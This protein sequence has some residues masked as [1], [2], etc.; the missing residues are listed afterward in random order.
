V[1]YYTVNDEKPWHFSADFPLDS[2][3]NPQL[4]LGAQGEI[5]DGIASAGTISYK[6]RNDIQIFTSM[7]RLDRR[8]VKD[9]S[10]ENGKCVLFTSEPLEKDLELTGF[11]VVELYVTST[12]K[13]GIFLAE[14]E[15]VMPD[16]FCQGI[17]EGM[18]RGRSAALGRNQITNSLGLPFHSSLKK[19]DIEL[20]ATVPTQLA[21][22]MEPTSRILKAGSRIRL[23]VYCGGNGFNQPEGMPDDVTVTFHFGGDN[24]ALLRLPVIAPNVTCFEGKD[25]TMY[26]FKRAVYRKTESGWK[27]Y[28]C[29]QVYP[30]ADGTRFVTDQ[31]TA[32]R[33]QDGDTVTL[34]VTDGP[35]TFTGTGKLSDRLTFSEQSTEIISTVDARIRRF[36]R[37]APSVKPTYR[38]LYVATVACKKE[39]VGQSNPQPVNTLDL[40]VDLALPEGEGPFPCIVS[41]HGFGGNNHQFDSLAAKFLERGYA[42]ASV[43]YRLMPPNIWPSSG[44]DT[45][46][47]I[48]YL[49]AH[50]AELKLDPERF[51]CIGGSMGGQL[52]AMVAACNGDPACEGDIGGNREFNSS[53]RAGVA[54]FGPTDLFHFGDDCAK[55]WPNELEKAANGDGPFAPPASMVGWVGAGRGMGDIK[56]HLFDSDP[57]YQ[58][59]IKLTKEASPVYHVT[60]KSAPL[61]LVHGIF[62]CGVQVPMG[63]S[64]RMFEALTVKGVKSLLLCNNNGIYGTDPEVQQAMLEFLCSRV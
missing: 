12:Y 5:V 38:N 31:F 13:D 22:R 14:L 45:N 1:Q 35:F 60:E 4:R 28:P 56:R 8:I 36:A 41:I 42:C 10:E 37:H 7:G 26:A 3:T 18:I 15:E 27:C 34:S 62:D 48:R 33:T 50:A 59:L 25:A 61:C 63:Q 17:T 44:V 43:E 30:A 58:A 23:A 54:L 40:H 6:V 39:E 29:T 24:D 32:L 51:G 53:V 2:Q 52:S 47:C 57:T 55:V 20:S 46:A 49:K 19:D 9:L 64:V 21:F 11:P 16:G